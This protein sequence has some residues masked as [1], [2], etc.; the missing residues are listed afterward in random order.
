MAEA[1]SAA[2]ADAGAAAPRRALV[3]VTPAMVT[4]DDD[5][6]L[7][8]EALDAVRCSRDARFADVLAV[9]SFVVDGAPVGGRDPASVSLEGAQL[10][11]VLPPFAG[12]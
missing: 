6:A 11:D 1:G 3:D 2:S 9:C 10:V 8:A 12:G 4:C 5:L 7:L